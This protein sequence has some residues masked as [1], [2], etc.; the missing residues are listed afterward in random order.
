MQVAVISS[1]RCHKVCMMIHF[2]HLNSEGRNRP[3]LKICNKNVEM[4]IVKSKGVS[5]SVYVVYL[6]QAI[7]CTLRVHIF[8][9]AICS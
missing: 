8:R 6:E 5:A 1:K 7:V 2:Q 4:K 9:A 3:S